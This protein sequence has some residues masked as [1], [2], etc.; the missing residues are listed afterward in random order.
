MIDI[1]FMA[2]GVRGRNLDKLDRED[3]DTKTIYNAR[4]TFPQKTDYLQKF[5]IVVYG[6]PR[7]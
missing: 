6:A 5:D 7:F 2:S 3:Q 1:D 4:F